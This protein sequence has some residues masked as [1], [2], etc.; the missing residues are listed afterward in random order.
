[1]SIKGLSIAGRKSND[2]ID[3]YQT[4]EW[5]TIE[6][7]KKEKFEGSILEPCSGG[8][9]ISKVLEQYGYNVISSDIR[10][11]IHVYGT[12]KQNM[13]DLQGF[14][15]NNIITNP[16]YFC[17][18]DA[19][20]KSLELTDKKVAMIFKLQFLE[21]QKRY[22]LFKSTPLKKVYV[23]CKRVV[24]WNELLQPDDGT[25]SKHGGTIAFAWY[26]WEHGY[27]GKPTIDWIL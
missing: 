8:G 20:K 16:P 9:A 7:L 19:I 14:Q 15:A 22:E 26:V 11:D 17:A 27:E 10:D 2:G 3:Y 13:F 25:R 4:P 24:M 5:A 6:L 18:E 21:S 12:K 1:M 23:F